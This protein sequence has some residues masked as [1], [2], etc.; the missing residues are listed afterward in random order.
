MIART[1]SPRKA[2]DLVFQLSGLLG[3]AAAKR[4]VGLRLALESKVDDAGSRELMIEYFRRLKAEKVPLPPALSDEIDKPKPDPAVLTKAIREMSAEDSARLF[5]AIDSIA[6]AQDALKTQLAN[7]QGRMLVVIEGAA[8][9]SCDIGAHFRAELLRNL[10]TPEKESTGSVGVM[11]V[12]STGPDRFQKELAA[13]ACF[14]N[15][16]ANCE[17]TGDF[18]KTLLRDASQK[19]EVV[20]GVQLVPTGDAQVTPEGRVQF[21]RSASAGNAS[22]LPTRLNPFKSAP[23]DAGCER[24]PEADQNAARLFFATMVDG[25]VALWSAGSSLPTESW[26]PT[27][28]GIAAAGVGGATVARAVALPLGIAPTQRRRCK[29]RL[30]RL[31]LGRN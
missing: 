13:A 30:R 17:K 29:Q 27:P 8:S 10:T 18:E 12:E 9:K 25:L 20:V 16:R 26:A 23:I 21:L 2:S 28:T 22:F 3:S 19:C 31:G 11:A 4:S 14:C 1:K 6:R 7:V 5:A 15:R 24:D